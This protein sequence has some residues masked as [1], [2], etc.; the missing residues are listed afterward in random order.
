MKLKKRRRLF[1]SAKVLLILALGCFALQ[2][3]SASVPSKINW[4]DFLARHDL[5]W[6]RAPMAWHDG[7]FLGNGMLGSMLHQMDDHTLRISLGRADVE[8]HKTSGGAFIAQSRLPN[9]Y[10]T[11]KT[12]GEITGFDG[13]LDLYN[14]E[15]RV[16]IQTDKGYVDLCGLVHSND[17]VIFYELKP[18]AGEVGIQLDFVPLK[19]KMGR[20]KISIQPGSGL[21]QS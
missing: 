1:C 21:D 13:R 14:A 18:S 9:G 10:F 17:M 20:L 8:D 16:R 12:V 3:V 5:V 2:Q 19:Q 6:K 4:P 15:T 7:P 11:L